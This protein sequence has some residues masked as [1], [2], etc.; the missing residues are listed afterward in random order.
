MTSGVTLRGEDAAIA[1]ASHSGTAAHVALVR[2]LLARSRC[3]CRRSAARRRRRPITRTRRARRSG[4]PRERVYMNCSA[5]TRDA[6]GVRRERLAARRLPRSRASAAEA[7]PRRP[8]AL[9]RRATGRHGVDG[10]GAPVHA[11]SLHA[12]AAASRRSRRRHLVAV[13]ALPR[14]AA[15]T[16]AAARTRGPWADPASPTRS[17][18]S[19]LGVFAKVGAEGVMVMTAPERHDDRGEGARRL[20]ACVTI[21][22]LRLLADAGAV[23]DAAV[24]A[25]QAELDL[26]VMGGERRVGEV[27]ATI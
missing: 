27:R 23:E 7:D 3:P 26:W 5:S 16:E 22:A 11:I 1:T 12:L 25:V 8:R 2:G 14:G 24:D 18:W 21:I 15:L 20:V 17:R 9:H 10:C 4:A 13:R 19:G 6:A